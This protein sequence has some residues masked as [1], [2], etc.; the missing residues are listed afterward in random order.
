[1]KDEPQERKLDFDWI[2]MGS[3]FGGSVSALRLSEKGYRVVVLERGRRFRD[4]DYAKST[5]DLRNFLWVPMLGL[6]GIFRLTPFKDVMI[7]SGSGVGGGSIVYA[8]TLYRAAPSFFANPQWAALADWASVLEA[9]LRRPPPACWASRLCRSKATI[10]S[11]SSRLGQSF[12]SRGNVHAACGVFSASRAGSGR[13]VLRRRRPAR[14]GCTR[15]G[16]CMVGC[17]VGAKNTLVKNYLWFA[18]RAARHPGRAAGRRR[19]AD[20]CGRWH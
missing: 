1:M 20:R 2:V 8:N 14:T 12:R 6:R 16:Q 15:C 5:W 9:S 10:K 13:S 18:E 19:A 11:S 7:A 3:G 4:Q 17:R